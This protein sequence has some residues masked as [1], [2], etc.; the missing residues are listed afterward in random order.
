L[1]GEIDSSPQDE[2]EATYSAPISKEEGKIDWNLSAVELW[3][4]V[5]AFSPWPGCYTVWRGKRLKIIEAVALPGGTVGGVGRVVVLEPSRESGAACGVVTGEGI[6]GIL[7]VQ[8]EGKQAIPTAEFLRG[9]RQFI[10]A[11]LPLG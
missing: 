11:V 1:R 6:L 8:L 9:Q 10:G 3:R 2:R 4:R 5:R 7:K